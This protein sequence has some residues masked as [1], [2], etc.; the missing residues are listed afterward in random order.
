MQN[1]PIDP[2]IACLFIISLHAGQMHMGNVSTYAH[3]MQVRAWFKQK[4]GGWQIV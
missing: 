3:P 1:T 2:S 4:F